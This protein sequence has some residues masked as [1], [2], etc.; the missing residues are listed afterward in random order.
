M[1]RNLKV[2]V[3]ASFEEENRAEYRRRARM[4]PQERM[5]EFAL[6][7]ERQWGAKWTSEPIVRKA[8]WEKVT[9]DK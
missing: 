3:Y 2:S 4:T 5:R 6:L 1:K 9:W 7:Q 8:W